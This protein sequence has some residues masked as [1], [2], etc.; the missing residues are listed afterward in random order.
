[1]KKESADELLNLVDRFEQHISVLKRLGEDTDSWDSLLI[2]Q[3]STR[4]DPHTQKEWESYCARLDSDNIA[5]VLGGVACDEA[6]END[7]PTYVSMVNYLQNY[8]RVLQCVNPSPGS[9][10]DRDP[11]VKP[12][13]SSVHFSSSSSTQA[14]ES[15]RRCEKCNQ[16]HFLYH[17]PDFQKLSEQHR[18]EFVK[19]KK[20]CSNCLR[21]T[22]HFAKSCQSKPCNRCP[23]KHHTLLQGAQFIQ[24]PSPGP[25]V[26]G[27]VTL[28]AQPSAPNPVQPTPSPVVNTPALPLQNLSQPLRLSPVVGSHP[29]Q[30]STAPTVPANLHYAMMACDKDN[31]HTA[32]ILPTALVEIED[33][34]GRKVL[35]RCLLDSGSQSH[36]ITKALCEKLQLPRTRASVPVLVCGIG[37]STTK[38]TH[39]VTAKVSSR[40]S[41]YVVEP[42]LLVLP[43]LA[44]K[45]PGSTISTQNWQIPETVR[46]A[47]PTF[48][49]SNEID[50]ILGAQFF[51]DILRYGRIQ[52]GEQL[53]VL[54]NS[55]LGWVVSG[56]CTIRDHDHADPRSCLMSSAVRV[57]EMLRK[58]WELETV[59]DT[60]GWSATDKFCEEHFLA[61]TTRTP[62][63]RYVVRLPKREELIAQLDDNMYQATRR[64]YSLERSLMSDAKK[65]K[66]YH[67]FV[68]QYIE[69]GHMR[70]VAEEELN[71]RPQFILPHHGDLKP[72]STT[73]KLRTV[74]DASCKSR[75]GLALNDV[76]IPGPTIQEM[77]VEIVLRFRLYRFVVT[78][79]I[80]KM[81][82]Q[83][84]VHLLDQ[85][86]QRILWRD[87]P[88]LRL[89]VYQ[90]LTITYGL[91]NSPFLATR[92]LQQLSTD[93][94]QRFPHAARIT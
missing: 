88:E 87:D 19:S 36:F 28:V 46:L 14:T 90:L 3:L 50:L 45:L 61:N 31:V 26:S 93:E 79:D 85:S 75:S 25:Q 44:I 84:L 53:P 55:V 54:Q 91:N 94:E 32:V 65:R 30:C 4:L 73:T 70:E 60:K 51:F 16:S 52:L 35:A 10:R 22:D 48:H 42:Q 49:V 68:T 89:K 64:F 56:P 21:S 2:Y 40:V 12:M 27:S 69:M 47:D 39:S 8:A 11:K 6:E 80:E 33:A 92:V 82:R 13:K 62:E 38:A 72:E 63:G 20:L 81:F 74:F 34:Q 78:A 29:A 76:M 77:L 1:M 41:P 37:Q 83:I 9:S 66:Q 86:L 17:C 7:M 5:N 67:D 57:E 71:V 24:Q 59:H 43:S 58:F 15:F 18:F 23:K